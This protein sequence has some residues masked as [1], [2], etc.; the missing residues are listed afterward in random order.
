MYRTS[1]LELDGT[2][3]F[4]RYEFHG[5][6]GEE[7]SLGQGGEI[8][9]HPCA[10]PFSGEYNNRLCHPCAFP[11]RSQYNNRFCHP[12]AFP[13]RSQC[14]NRSGQDFCTTCKETGSVRFPADRWEHTL[15]TIAAQASLGIATGTAFDSSARFGASNSGDQVF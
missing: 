12:S 7:V 3:F 1:N 11:F 2:A 4:R 9:C 5:A 15:E 10:L 6:G 8:D 13:F 14:N